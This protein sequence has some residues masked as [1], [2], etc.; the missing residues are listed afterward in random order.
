MERIVRLDGAVTGF[1]VTGRYIDCM[2]GRELLKADKCSGEI[3]Y[4]KT[5]FEREGFSRK[6]AADR[7]EIYLYDFCTLYAFAQEDYALLG[8]W[9]LG[10]DLRSDICAMAVDE[11]TVYC[12]IRNGKIF[13]LDRR[14]GSIREVSVSGSSMWSLKPYGR[15]LLCGTVDGRLLLLDRAAI[16]IEQTLV[17]GR[18]NIGSLYLD[19]ETLYAAGHDGKLF[20]ISMK[21]LEAEKLIK[22]AHKKMFG[23]IGTY[24]DSVVTVSHPCSEIAMWD[25]HTLER[26]K[27]IPVPL[28]LSGQAYI[29]EDCMYIS[30]RNIFGIA[31]VRLSD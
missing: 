18:K 7:G 14:S 3:V 11:D 10:D 28:R 8:K 2:C 12:S 27:V 26:I 9:R 22:N 17:L 19:G 4:R 25:K 21:S 30:S 20:K 16:S 24:H 5:V 1:H 23:C 6:L 13:T 29:E 15:H 31:R